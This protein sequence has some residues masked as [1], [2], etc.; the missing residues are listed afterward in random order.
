MNAGNISSAEDNN[1]VSNWEDIIR[2]ILN[3]THQAKSK[4]K[5]YSAPPSPSRV[6]A[7]DASNTIADEM[8][9]PEKGAA[10]NEDDNLLSERIGKYTIRDW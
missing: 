5:C 1:F 3:R 4:C 9:S 6:K 2:R 7:S 8:I 10:N